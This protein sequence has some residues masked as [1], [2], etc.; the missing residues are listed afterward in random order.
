[1]RE[2]RAAIPDRDDGDD[3]EAHLGAIPDAFLIDCDRDTVVLFEVEDSTPVS[4]AKME[5]YTNLFWMLDWYSWGLVIVTLDRWGNYRAEFDVCS[6]TAKKLILDAKRRP[7]KERSSPT[8]K[9]TRKRS[10]KHDTRISCC[11]LPDCG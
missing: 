2:I 7:R 4:E 8:F 1:M 6:Y 3:L 10:P 11:V 9:R 5:I